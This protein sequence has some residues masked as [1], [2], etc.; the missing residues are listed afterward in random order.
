[1]LFDLGPKESRADL[2]G[3]DEELGEVDRFLKGPSRLLMIYGIRRIG[4]TSVLKAAL[5]S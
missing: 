2:F 3:R 1:M 4:K 5:N